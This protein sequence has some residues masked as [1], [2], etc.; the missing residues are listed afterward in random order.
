MLA[1]G[2]QNAAAQLAKGEGDADFLK[3]KVRTAR[4]FADHVMAQ[5]PALASAATRGAESVL[6]S[7]EAL[8]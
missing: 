4:F 5:A 7:E 6:G 2:A 1:R 3:G 8:L